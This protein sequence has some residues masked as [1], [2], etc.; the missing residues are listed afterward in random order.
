MADQPIAI[1]DFFYDEQIRRYLYQ[2]VRAFSGFQYMP[3]NG[4]PRL[5]PCRM[6]T[7]NR[8]VGHI[9]RNNSENTLMTCPMITVFIKGL[10][11]N[12]ERTQ[13]PSFISRVAVNERAI[14][15]TT[16]TYTNTL[17]NQ[18]TVERRMPHPV[19]ATIQID[20]WTSNEMQKHQLFEQMFIMFNPGFDIQSSDNPL[21]WT[22]LTT[23]L[24]ED[25]TWSS[26][27]IPIGTGDEIDIMSFT[28]KLPLWI[29]PPALVKEQHLIQQVVTNLYGGGIDYKDVN[30]G[31]MLPD[32]V[33][34]ESIDYAATG[35]PMGTV[36]TTPGDNQ[37]MVE[38]FYDATTSE[39]HVEVT[40][41]GP[42]GQVDDAK[43][44]IFNWSTFLQQYG[45]L[46]PAQSTL[47]LAHTIEDDDTSLDT[48]GTIQLDPTRANVLIWQIDPDTLPG[49]TV[50][51]IN[52]IINPQERYPGD[53]ALPLPAVGQRYLLL[54]DF[55][56]NNTAWGGNP[57]NFITASEG[58]IIQYGPNGWFVAFVAASTTTIN[59]VLNLRSYKQL[60]FDPTSHQW[61]MAIDGHY[62]PG[63]WRL[64]M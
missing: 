27:A 5:V 62:N 49:N 4:I 28:F 3:G 22:A 64:S 45:P 41:L 33:G 53:G 55:T 56:T 7:Q 61:H 32:A 10:A 14:D 9:M 23:M 54:H 52:G 37:I 63:Y 11:I 17:G 36:V 16:N 20:V 31:S 30:N 46:R 48:I 15:A 43:G 42:G 13:D 50:N 47:R 19:D 38:T 1:Y 60:K 8:Q 25:V 44:N 18:Y 21:D 58:D 40:L 35:Q 34:N 51:A 57:S 26:R 2:I 39:S 12:R 29:N 59:F 24:L 6:A